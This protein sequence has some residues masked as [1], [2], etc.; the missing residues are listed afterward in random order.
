MSMAT[1][2]REITQEAKILFNNPKLRKKDILAWSTGDIKKEGETDC[3]A[4]IQ[5]LSIQVC[6]HKD[7]DKR[8]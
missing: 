5:K 6:I 8:K 7:F 4:T 3:I 2:E 1:L